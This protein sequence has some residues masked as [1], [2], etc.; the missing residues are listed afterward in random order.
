MP[1]APAERHKCGSGSGAMANIRYDIVKT[2]RG[3]SIVCDGVLGGVPYL[4][5]EA[6]LRDATW[7]ADLLGKA[8]EDVKIYLGGDPVEINPGEAPAGSRSG[9][10]PVSSDPPS[11]VGPNLSGRAMTT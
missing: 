7:A 8:G 10:G 6:A 5:R 11:A 4:Q 1:V 2:L 3:W 9:S